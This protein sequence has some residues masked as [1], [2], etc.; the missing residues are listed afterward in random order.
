MS[1]RWTLADV[2]DLRGRTAVVTGASTGLGFETARLLLQR[3]VTV[4][5]TARTGDKADQAV[6]RLRSTAPGGRVTGLELELGSLASVAAAAQRLRADHERLD[7]LVNNAGMLGSAERTTTQD[8]FESTFGANHLGVFALTGALL[9]PLLAAPGSR[10]V[11]LT[12]LTVRGVGLDLDDLQS[13]HGYRRD[14]TYSRSKLANLLF[15]RELQ[16]RLAA[17]GASTL[18]LAAHPGQSRTD[19]TRGLNPAARLLYSPRMRSVTGWMMQDKAVGVLATL[20]AATDPAATGGQC[21]GPSGPLQ[22]TGHPVPVALA[23]DVDEP[24]ARRLWE[25]SEAL[26]GVRYALPDQQV[27]GGPPP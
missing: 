9:E 15:A 10:V 25:A 20:R 27:T 7:L 22:L 8:G 14:R 21:Y 16:R 5:A 18:S 23:T 26:T 24:V 17:A 6:A 1:A 12:S 19:F 4:V 3:G 2:P 11:T 13:E